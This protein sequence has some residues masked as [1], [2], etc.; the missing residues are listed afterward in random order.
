MIE[1][2]IDLKTR[3]QKRVEFLKTLDQLLSDLRREE[4]SLQYRYRQNDDDITQIHLHAEWQTWENL[5]NHLRGDFFSILMGA[6]RVLCEKPV[7]RI[8]NGAGELEP[9]IVHN[10]L[11]KLENQ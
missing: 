8:D 10:K 3:P 6:I 1:L 9:D 4:G 7:V 11:N 2:N 5:E